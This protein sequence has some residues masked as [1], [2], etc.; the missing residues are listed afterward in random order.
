MFFGDLGT[1]F[2]D[3]GCDWECDWGVGGV[4]VRAPSSQNVID[5]RAVRAG[6]AKLRGRMQ[7]V[8]LIAGPPGCE[9]PGVFRASF[10][11]VF[12]VIYMGFKWFWVV[13]VASSLFFVGICMGFKALPRSFVHSCMGFK[14]HLSKPM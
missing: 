6:E 12:A 3:Y 10:R 7:T 14:R 5:V 9:Y 8:V 11:F 4:W 1:T 2:Y 13:F